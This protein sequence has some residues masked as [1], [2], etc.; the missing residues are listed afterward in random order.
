M[1][2]HLGEVFH[3][4]AKHKE[5][6][7]EEACYAGSRAHVDQCAAKIG[8]IERGGIHQGQECDSCGEALFEERAKLRRA[9]DLGPGVFSLIRLAGIPKPSAST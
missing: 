1:R 7:I 3:R 8:G 6:W 9:A 2:K 5:C 4:L